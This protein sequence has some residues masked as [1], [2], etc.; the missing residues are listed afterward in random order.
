MEQNKNEQVEQNKKAPVKDPR[1]AVYIYASEGVDD[2][3]FL[4][5]GG[6]DTQNNSYQIK[7]EEWANIPM[8]ILHILENSIVHTTEYTEEENGVF[9]KR[10]VKRH[11]YHFRTRPIAA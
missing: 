7:R 6:K 9:T 11:N 1:I 3:V 5:I 8:S 4:Q 2:D 10:P